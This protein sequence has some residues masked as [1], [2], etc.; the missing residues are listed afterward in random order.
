MSADLPNYVPEKPVDP[1]DKSVAKEAAFSKPGHTSK[2]KGWAP[3]KGTRFRPTNEKA[4]GRRR[5]RPLDPRR[6]QFY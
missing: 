6:V 4:P 5:K 2:G 3:A 1:V